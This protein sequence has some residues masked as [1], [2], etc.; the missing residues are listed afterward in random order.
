MVLKIEVRQHGTKSYAVI[1][2]ESDASDTYIMDLFPTEE[3]A[4]KEANE[5]KGSIPIYAG[6]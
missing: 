5:L 6:H 2:H 3:L 4:R 1:V